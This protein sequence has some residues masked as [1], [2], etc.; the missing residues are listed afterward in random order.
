MYSNSN[1]FSQDKPDRSI[2]MMTEPG[3]I[4]KVGM[5]S[6]GVGVSL[7]LLVA[8]KVP[9]D[10]LPIHILLRTALDSNSVREWQDKIEALPSH[11]RGTTSAIVAED[12]TGTTFSF[13]SFIFFPLRL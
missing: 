13:P 4:G 3:I 2:M 5:N 11:F 12:E 1:F 7:N 9:K 8:K 6:S 10:G